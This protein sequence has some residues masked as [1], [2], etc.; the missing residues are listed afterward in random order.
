[1][2]S[3]AARVAAVPR[4]VMAL[5]AVL[6]AVAIFGLSSLPG[7]SFG[8]GT[9][10][11]GFLLNLGHAPLFGGLAGLVTF[12]ALPREPIPFVE[13]GRMLGAFT[14][15]VLYAASDELHQSTVAGRSADVLDLLTDSAGAWGG[16]LFAAAVVRRASGGPFRP[17]SL[18]APVI[19]AVAAA[20]S[21]TL[22][23]A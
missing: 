15:V 12:A 18:V 10:W 4:A 2:T 19:C 11:R 7:A 1:M 8:D 5:L 21:A 22:R 6:W 9:T 20:A 23:A 16:V 3:A 13:R 17:R 14:L